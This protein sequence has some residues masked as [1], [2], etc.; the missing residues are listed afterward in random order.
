MTLG[1]PPRL[2]ETDG[3]D[4]AL[5]T[6]M[7]RAAAHDV[8]YDV[9]AG[10]ARFEATLTAG[11][12]P[13]GGGAG[14]SAAAAGKGSLWVVAAVAA[15][16]IGGAVTW[17]QWGGAGPEAV[18]AVAV[19]D[20]PSAEPVPAMEPPT[21]SVPATPAAIT[22]AEQTPEVVEDPD[23]LILSDD[24]S[25]EPVAKV[26]PSR[27]AARPSQGRP[28]HDD[29]PAT[30]PDDDS[31]RR[32]MQATQRARQA[33]STD[34]ARALALVRKAN[35]EFSHGLFTEDREGIAVLALFGLGR[36][37][38]ARRRAAAFLRAHPRSSYADKIRAAMSA[39]DKP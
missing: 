34:P 28:R 29:P 22:V 7:A 26:R 4:P 35:T 39:S 13:P 37:D 38:K 2:L 5:H 17:S 14:A 8:G 21:P 27:P 15:V 18:A 33:L 19:D 1:P 36:N 20:P 31:L 25:D 32:E 16:V 6:D 11:G 10:A 30:T 12:P 9:V 23:E 3:L 24:P